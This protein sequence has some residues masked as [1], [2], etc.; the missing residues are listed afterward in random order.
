MD[1]EVEQLQPSSFS[2]LRDVGPPSLLMSPF[3]LLRNLY[4]ERILIKHLVKRD[5]AVKY[6]S[7]LLGYIWTVLEPIVMTAT[8]YILFMILMEPKD[9]FRVLNLMLGILTWNLFRAITN[10]STMALK[11]SR[12]LIQTIYIPREIFIFSKMFTT[13]VIYLLSLLICIPLLIMF[14]LKPN[15]YF[16]YLPL[17]I[18]NIC[19][20]GTG[21]GMCL[22]S[23]VPRFAD[24]QNMVSLT[25]RIMFYL[26]PVFYTLDYMSRVPKEVMSIYLYANPM[27]I[28]IS[29]TRSAFT[30]N[31]PSMVGL[32]H[33]L[34][35]TGIAVFF[36]IIGTMIFS[37]SNFKAVK[38]L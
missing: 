9:E 27:A 35:S 5:L 19:L 21:I 2:E 31:I 23:L 33:I 29:L 30:G 10:D 18:L 8:F 4:Q 16:F 12:G 24:V 3:V 22:A 15:L 32:E 37:K 14:G 11:K 25:L 6:N 38:F 13:L 34:F 1:G 36:F 7:P 26:T 28:F 20:L 17:S